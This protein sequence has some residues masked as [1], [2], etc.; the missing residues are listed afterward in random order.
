MFTLTPHKETPHA[1]PRDVLEPWPPFDPA[2]TAVEG[3]VAK[4][5]TLLAIAGTDLI[6]PILDSR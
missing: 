3:G 4:A 2:R 1:V 5:L 6:P